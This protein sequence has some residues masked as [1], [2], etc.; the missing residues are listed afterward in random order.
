MK[1]DIRAGK[2]SWMYGWAFITFVTL[3]KDVS[4]TC[5]IGRKK[6]PGEGIKDRI[7]S[8][9]LFIHTYQFLGQFFIFV[10][11]YGT[12]IQQFW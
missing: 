12:Y 1:C 9:K 3:K 6:S 11:V 8:S 2:S 5:E 7:N 4:I 10:T